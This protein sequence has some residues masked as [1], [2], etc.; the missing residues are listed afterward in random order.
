V[1]LRGAVV[2]LELDRLD[3]AQVIDVEVA[4]ERFLEL[5]LQKG[6]RVYVSPRAVETGS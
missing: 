5:G 1:R 3:Q 2:K 6:D 4:R